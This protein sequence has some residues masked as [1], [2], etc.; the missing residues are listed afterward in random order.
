MADKL[1]I[2]P[3]STITQV[4]KERINL[5]PDR[6]AQIYGEERMTYG[7]FGERVDKLASGLS[8]LGVLPGEKVALIL[9]SGNT[10][11]VVM[12]AVIQMGGISVGI[13][14][15]LRTNEFKHIFSDS[16]AVAVIISDSV[17]G[18][19]P[20]GVIREMR[21]G[22]PDLR[23][24]IVDGEEKEGEINLEDLIARSTEKDEY[25]QANP[26]DLAALV[27]TSGTTGLPKGSMHSHY[28]MLY[29][30]MGGSLLPPVNKQV[31]NII[32]RYGLRYFLRVA[33]AIN[34]PNIG[35]SSLPPYTGGGSMSV[36]GSFLGG[37]TK[38][39]MS[40]FTPTNLLALIE[41]ERLI[42]ISLPPALG[43]M[44]IRSPN[45]DKYDLSSLMVVSLVAAPV[46]P[47]LIDEFKEKL[48][49]PI[50]NGFGAT[51]LFTGPTTVSPFT[52]QM[53]VLR[54]SIGKVR[55]GFEVKIVDEDRNPLP[56]EEVGEL[57]V[58]GGPPM[59]GYYKADEL[60]Q[61][62]FD[63]EGW[64]YTGDQAT[65]DEEGF[66]RIVGRIKDMI[67]R[68]GQNVYPAELENILVTH[69]KVQDAA[70][71]GVPDP[72]SGEKVLAYII[73]KGDPAPTVVDLLNFCRENMAPYKVPGNVVFVDEFPLNATG[74]VLKRALREEAIS[75]L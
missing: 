47:A 63:E 30:M 65:M 41:K 15:T 29:P 17:P 73:P 58:R 50:L 68:G 62:T 9:P 69:P 70:V 66:I 2:T 71:I 18:V 34:K 60:T 54:E 75:K 11:P 61:K 28:T 6:L 23:H 67:I 8:D 32:R 45:F 12:Y 56:A 19:D 49:C 48:G 31:I 16:E 22:L 52:D 20:L 46:P 44:L 26:N 5:H 64:Y 4:L 59:L 36:I 51:E 38:V 14:P 74:K 24:V 55:P 72:I 40:R 35:Y 3:E 21:V 53:S 7:Q 10:F 42:S 57:V 39:Q 25:H 37:S 33:V 13:N 43:M 27:Y 1:V